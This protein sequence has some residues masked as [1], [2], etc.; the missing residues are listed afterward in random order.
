MF[1]EMNR[2]IAL[3]C[4]RPVIDRIFEFEELPDALNYLAN[5]SHFGKV[6]IRVCAGA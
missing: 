4:L 5:G 2:A 1:E 3:S 6:G